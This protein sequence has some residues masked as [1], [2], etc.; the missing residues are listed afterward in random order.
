MVPYQ[1][2]RLHAR[3][4]ISWQ[5]IHSTHALQWLDES[6]RQDGARLSKTVQHELF[7]EKVQSGE[8]NMTNCINIIAADICTDI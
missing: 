2:V 8:K 1:Q 4:P 7:H 3:L 6:F 5:N